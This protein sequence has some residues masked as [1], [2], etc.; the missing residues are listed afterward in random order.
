MEQKLNVIFSV[1]EV[2]NYHLPHDDGMILN[3]AAYVW[4][5]K[6]NAQLGPFLEVILECMIALRPDNIY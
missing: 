3:V 5:T 2:N 1:M 6:L 4:G